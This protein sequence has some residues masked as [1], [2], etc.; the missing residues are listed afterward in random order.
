MATHP[1]AQKVVPKVDYEWSMLQVTARA[2]DIGLAQGSPMSNAL[3]E[4]FLVHARVLFD[5][6]CTPP[7]HPTHYRGEEDD[8]SAEQ[9][10]DDPQTWHTIREKLFPTFKERITEVNK[11]LAHLTYTR[12]EE[13]PIWEFGDSFKEFEDARDQFLAALPEERRAWFSQLVYREGV[14]YWQEIENE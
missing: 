3:L 8:V 1:Y 7:T 12:I 11:H 10:F 4:T 2:M 14:N 6:Y 13:K 5:F 9:F